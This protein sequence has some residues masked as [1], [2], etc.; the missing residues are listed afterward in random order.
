MRIFAASDLHTDFAE[1]RRRL[2]QISSTSYLQDVLIVAGDIA[3]DLRIIDWTLRKLRS[4]FGRVFYV[5]GNH[6]LWVREVEY[7]SVEKFRQVIRLCDEIGINT[8]PGS[9]RG[10]NPITINRA[11]RMFPRWR[12]GPIFISANGRS[13]WGPSRNTFSASMN[14]GSRNMLVL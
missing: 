6:E 1:N 11:R 5:P 12:G 8:R 10:M 13:G 2:Q 9:S 14:R 3:D 4:Q 7:D